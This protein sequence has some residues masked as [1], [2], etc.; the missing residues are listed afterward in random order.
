MIVDS[1]TH[2]EVY[3]ELEKGFSFGALKAGDVLVKPG[4]VI[5]ADFDGVVVIPSEIFN[6]VLD[7]AFEK[8]RKESHTRQELFEGKLLAEVYEKYGVL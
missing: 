6:E 4:D 7:R 2:A 1:M 3:A 8:C 5:F